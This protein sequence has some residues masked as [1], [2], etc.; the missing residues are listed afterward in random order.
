[1]QAAI[2]GLN[3]WFGAR[4]ARIILTTDDNRTRVSS[5]APLMALLLGV[6]AVSTASTLIRVAQREVSSLGVAAWR[7]TFATLILAPFAL[8]TCRDSWRRLNRRKWALLVISGVVLA[9]HFYTWITSLALTSVAASTVLVATNPLFVALISHFF[10]R[11]RLTKSVIIG[12]LVAIAGSVLIGVSDAGQGS[13]Q[14]IGDL[15][16]LTGALAVAIYLLIGRRLR[17][18]LP[19]LAYIFPVYGTAAVVLMGLAL[20]AGVPL[21][22][23]TP[24][25][26]LLLGL[27]A[28]IP[29]ILGHSSF[30]WALGH[31]PA[32]YV[33]LATLTE[34]VGSTLLAWT[35]LKES[36]TLITVVGGA[37]TLVGIGITLHRP[38]RSTGAL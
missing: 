3:Y 27:I 32:T 20:I 4:K 10:L 23:Y 29:Q 22:G 9:V 2:G 36:P 5:V 19:L 14:I 8:T 11:D 30:N 34:P 24:T 21:G 33:A 35:L 17:A 31:L 16:A 6:I 26:W 18:E 25:A 38:R 7:L 12:L 37:L 28:L 1:M 15:L 13:H